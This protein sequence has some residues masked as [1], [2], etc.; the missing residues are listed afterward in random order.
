MNQRKL[1]HNEGGPQIYKSSLDCILTVSIV[2]YSIFLSGCF[3]LHSLNACTRNII[4]I[5][6]QIWLPL[7]LP[8]RDNQPIRCVSYIRLT[9][10]M[11]TRPVRGSDSGSGSQIW[12]FL[13]LIFLPALDPMQDTHICCKNRFFK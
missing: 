2:F 10:Q 1:K 6:V 8:L 11:C 4:N 13:I 5:E 3:Q 12:T 7:P 9:N